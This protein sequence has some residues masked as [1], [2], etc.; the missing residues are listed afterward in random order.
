M[1]D[2]YV[3]VPVLV[4]KLYAAGTC[5]TGNWVKGNDCGFANYTADTNACGFV[6]MEPGVAGSYFTALILGSVYMSAVDTIKAGAPIRA[7]CTGT[8][9]SVDVADSTYKTIAICVD[10]TSTNATTTR[11]TRVVLVP[12]GGVQVTSW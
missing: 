5:T 2:N 7:D 1:A 6:A 9:G 12:P 10:G 11:T 8:A 3:D 4:C